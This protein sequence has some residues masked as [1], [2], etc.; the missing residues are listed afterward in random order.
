MTAIATVTA[1]SLH[2]RGVPHKE[3]EVV[4]YLKKDDK[5]VVL[6]RKAFGAH[7]WLKIKMPNKSEGWVYSKYVTVASNVPDFEPVE[8]PIP[9]TSLAKMFAWVVGIIVVCSIIAWFVR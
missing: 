6:E 4:G 3:G 5:A 2:V 1:E 7:V 9:D 8:I